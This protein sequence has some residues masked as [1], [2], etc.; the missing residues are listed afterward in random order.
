MF[1]L[2][3]ISFRGVDSSP[4]P[5]GRCLDNRVRLLL[6]ERDGPPPSPPAAPLEVDSLLGWMLQRAGLEVGAYRATVLQRRLPAC[7]RRLKAASATEAQELL[8]RKPELLP[9]ALSAILIGVSDFFRDAEVFAEVQDTILPYLLRERAGLRVCSVGASGGHEVYSMAMLLAEQGALE[10]SDLLGVDCRRDAISSAV[11]GAF[12]EGEMSG[13]DAA[14]R[15]RFFHAEGGRW[16]VRT[17]L[18]RSLRWRV[19]DVLTFA[20][21]DPGEGE[22]GEAGGADWDVI[23]FRNVSIYFNDDASIGA[24][25]RLTAR[26]APGGFLITGKA[27]QPPAALPLQRVSSAIYQKLRA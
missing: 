12:G 11:V 9:F 5:G 16:V 22:G 27:E 13:V 20:E 24:W 17:E 21:A 8:E 25:A 4:I 10:R 18:R 14:R 6:G 26:L 19:A 1:D 3:Y 15:A 23:L 7:L 2:D